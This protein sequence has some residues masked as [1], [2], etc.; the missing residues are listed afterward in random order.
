M[1]NFVMD[2]NGPSTWGQSA[3]IYYDTDYEEYKVVFFKGGAHLEEA[4]YHTEDY[5]DAVNTA[6]M[7]LGE[8]WS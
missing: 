8:R 5:E 2:L 1:R 7:Q 6:K 4:D 3:R